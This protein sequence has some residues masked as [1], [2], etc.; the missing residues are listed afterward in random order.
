MKTRFFTAIMTLLMVSTWNLSASEKDSKS[1]SPVSKTLISGVI[2]DKSSN[3]KLAGVM[4]RILSTGQK[5]YTDAKGEF[6]LEGMEP[7]TY[8]VSVDCISYK[9]KTLT[10]KII[11]GEKEKL[12]IQLNPIEP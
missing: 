9:N 12:T 7:G 8:Q 2:T 6:S 5:V 3:E 1:S 10:V 11:K 4:V